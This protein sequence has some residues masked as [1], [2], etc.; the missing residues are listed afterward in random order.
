ML[1]VHRVEAR[2]LRLSANDLALELSLGAKVKTDGRD[3]D[4]SVIIVSSVLIG[5]WSRGKEN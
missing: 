1:T 3:H 2:I 4:A 5:G